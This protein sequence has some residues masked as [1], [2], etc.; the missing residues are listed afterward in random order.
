M[1]PYR[2]IEHGAD[3]GIEAWADNLEE[4]FSDGADALLSVIFD[5]STIEPNRSVEIT[6]EAPVVDL[7]F[8]EVINELLS[9]I[10]IETLALEGL[11]VL[12]L[13]EIDGLKNGGGGLKGWSFKGNLRGEALDTKK[14]KVRTEVKAAT[15][16]GLSYEISGSMHLLR[17]VVDV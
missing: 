17:C 7:L 12:E 6:A 13:K 1:M 11:E 10:D 8:V 3:V 2:Y 9:T 15:Y 14:H 16:S 5:T 4:A